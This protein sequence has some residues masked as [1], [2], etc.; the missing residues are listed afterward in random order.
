MSQAG[1]CVTREPSAILSSTPRCHPLALINPC[2]L[3]QG[4][5]QVRF[6]LTCYSLAPQIKVSCCSCPWGVEVRAGHGGPGSDRVSPCAVGLSS[7]TPWHPG[8]CKEPSRWEVAVSRRV[9]IFTAILSSWRCSPGTR[10]GIDIS[11]CCILT[12]FWMCD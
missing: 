11:A 4:N 2:S 7:V 6:E 8:S 1:T 3:F 9:A 10:G 5:D 12:P